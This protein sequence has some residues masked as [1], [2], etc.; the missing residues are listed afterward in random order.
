MKPIIICA[1]D[2]THTS[3]GIRA[4]HDLCHHINM[5]GGTARLL[6]VCEHA[7]KSCE[8]AQMNPDWCTLGLQES[9]RHFIEDGIVIYPETVHGNPLHA[10]RVVRWMGNK[11]GVLRKKRAWTM[12]RLTSSS[13]IRG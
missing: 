6:L 13:R 3:N 5:L 1:P 10:K 8:P 7:I 12:R 2:Y 4:L 9:E 11:E